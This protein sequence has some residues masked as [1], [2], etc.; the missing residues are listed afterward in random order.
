LKNPLNKAYYK[1]KIVLTFSIVTILTVTVL[2]RVNYVLVKELYLNQLS[3]NINKTIKITADQVDYTYFSLLESGITTKSTKRYFNNFF[4]KSNFSEIY[5]EI[6][7]IDNLLNI[8]VHSDTNKK[9]NIP[10]PRYLLNQKELIDLDVKKSF[11]SLPF[12]GNDSQ[13]YLWG[14]YRLSDKHYLGVKESV[15]NFE[16]VE[17]LSTVIW[18]FGTA[19]IIVSIILGI[20]V[21]NS[22][23]K[24]IRKLILFSDEI[25][26][27]NLNADAPENMKGELLLL[28][29]ALSDMRNNI[30]NNQKEKEKMLAQIAHEIRNPL[31]G[32][33]LLAN[34]IN[35]SSSDEGKNKEYTN[36]IIS[37]I[38]ELKL[39]INAYL[40]YSKPNRPNPEVVDLKELIA[41]CTSIFENDIKSNGINLLV[42]HELQ[43]IVFDRTH[44]KNILINLIKNS[45]ES[46]EEHGEIKISTF[47]RYNF[48]YMIIEDN[49]KGIKPGE[50][51]NIFDPFFTTK[52]NGTGLGLASCKKYCEDNS[53]E[54]KVEQIEFGCKFIIQKE[55][56]NE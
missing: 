4:N 35:E 22:I 25:G 37:E 50:F 45:I 34:L 48:D 51:Q 43:N 20:V 26:E 6:F 13:W 2:A 30:S 46:I 18:Y 47:T 39:L 56:S 7:I 31:G 24:P 52:P 32:I 21:S 33:E 44:L 54:L 19:G 10:D 14:F 55:K 38:S 9:L 42:N 8:V 5:A 41:D 27:G 3:N 36:R 49:G 16:K 53:A 11:V 15:A 17:Q 40:D 23:T 28:T 12:K 29:N 1:Y